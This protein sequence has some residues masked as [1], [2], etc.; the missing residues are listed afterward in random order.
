MRVILFPFLILL[1][2]GGCLFSPILYL[3]EAP[4]RLSNIYTDDFKFVLIP[5]VLMWIGILFYVFV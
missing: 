3:I 5:G 1:Y 2:I 4:K